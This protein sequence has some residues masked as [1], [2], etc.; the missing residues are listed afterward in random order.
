MTCM[1]S[2]SIQG[3][4]SIVPLLLARNTGEYRYAMVELLKSRTAVI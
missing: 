2:G 3:R 4:G 1:S